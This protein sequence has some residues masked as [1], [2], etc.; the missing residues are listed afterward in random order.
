MSFFSQDSDKGL[1]FFIALQSILWKPTHPSFPSVLQSLPSR[2]ECISAH[3]GWRHW[4]EEISSLSDPHSLPWKSQRI[5][6][7][8]D[9]SG[10]NGNWYLHSSLQGFRHLF[11]APLLGTKYFISKWPSVQLLYLSVFEACFRW[12]LDLSTPSVIH[13]KSEYTTRVGFKCHQ[14]VLWKAPA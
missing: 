3:C 4:W 9:E 8:P 5:Y 12:L 14:I 2:T 1:D 10:K 11:N 13:L 6:I 7:K